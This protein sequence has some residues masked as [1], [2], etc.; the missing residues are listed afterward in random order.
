M[1]GRRCGDAMIDWR[2]APEEY[3]LT[4]ELAFMLMP[5]GGG[6]A[7]QRYGQGLAKVAKQR[8][9]AAGAALPGLR[10]RDAEG[11]TA[12]E[13]RA[14][15]A[16]PQ[17]RAKLKADVILKLY[18]QGR[19]E[20]AHVRAAEEIRDVYEGLARG[21]QPATHVVMRVDGGQ[22][23]D[24]LQ[25]MTSWERDRFDARYLPWLLDLVTGPPER[26]RGQR[27]VVYRCAL[28][29]AM[30]V[31]VHNHGVKSAARRCRIDHLQNGMG[32]ALLRI[33]LDRY[34]MLAGFRAGENLNENLELNRAA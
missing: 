30:A 3:T 6:G 18:R 1:A 4:P 24:P 15:A 21:M 8:L 20:Q 23:R 27:R 13:R 7:A 10:P 28:W 5:G 16:T 2:D 25:R 22:W 29:L 12:E 14:G 26:Q 32:T 33:V 34:A 11:L 17:T 9:A 19:I 31:V